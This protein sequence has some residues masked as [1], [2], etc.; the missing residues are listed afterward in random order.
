M[1]DVR[2]D[3]DAALLQALDAV[4]ELAERV[5]GGHREERISGATQLPNFIRKPQGPGWA[6]VGDAGCHKDPY[7]ALGVCDAFRDAQ[8]LADALHDGLTGERPVDEALAG[9]ERARDAATTA[10]FHA[11]VAAAKL[12]PPPRELLALRAAIRG[13]EEETRRFFMAHEGRVDRAAYFSQENIG[14]IMAT[15]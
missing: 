2:A 13:D 10:D 15:A 12:G 8:L 4:P 11:N 14:R 3:L 7:Y 6:L 5:R 9:Y 1:H